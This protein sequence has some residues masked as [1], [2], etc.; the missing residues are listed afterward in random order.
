VTDEQIRELLTHGIHPRWQKAHTKLLDALVQELPHW[1][2]E[3][4]KADLLEGTSAEHLRQH[5]VEFITHVITRELQYIN[6]LRLRYAEFNKR[7]AR[8]ATEEEKRQHV[9]DY[10]QDLGAGKR[11]LASDRRAF[12]RWFGH[13]AVTDRYSRRHAGAERKIAMCLQR[14]GALAAFVLSHDGPTVGYRQ[15]WTRLDLETLSKS[16]LTYDGDV[17]V[18]IEA[19]RCL[20]TA[21]QAL[22]SELQEGSVNEKTLQYIYRAAIDTRQQVWIQCEALRL[23]QS[24]SAEALWTALERRLSQPH[25]GDDLFVRRR[26][27]LVLGEN[28][29]RLPHL[30]TLIPTA[31]RDPSP[32]VRQ[33][34]ARALRSATLEDIQTWLHHLACQDTTPQVRAAALL[35]V[36]VLLDRTALFDILAGIVADSLERE[37][38]S[39]VLRVAL[40][41]VTDGVLHYMQEGKD[42]LIQYWQEQLLPRIETL[43]READSLSVRRWAAQAWERIWCESDPRARALRQQLEHTVAGLRSGKSMRLPHRVLDGYDDEMVGRVLS[44]M[45]QD[46]FGYDIKRG[47]WG[48]RITRGHVFGLRWWRV[49]YE[50]RHPSPDKR[51]AFRHTIGRHFRGFLRAPSAILAELAETKVPGEPLHL[52]TESGW[53]PYLPL[54]DEVLSCLDETLRPQP[55]QIFTSEGVTTLTPPTSLWQRL[56]AQVELARNFAHYARLRNWQEQ[57]QASPNAY[58]QAVRKLGLRVHFRTHQPAS[59]RALSADPAVE[60]FF[61]AALPFS[62]GEWWPR[63]QEYFFSAYENSL[64]ELSI[65]MTLA[66]GFFIG[67][68]LYLNYTL[69]RVRDRFP[70]VVGGWGTRG[71]SGTE[72]IKAAMLNALGYSIVSKTTGCEAMFLH[73]HPFHQV[74]EMFLFRPYDKATIWE[75]ANLMRLADKLDTDVFLWECMALSPSYVYLLQKHWVRDEIATITNTFP[76][77]EDIQGPAGI[78]IPQVMVNFIPRGTTLFT[79]EEQMK[80]ILDEG[81][82]DLD[83]TIGGVGWL[84]AGLLTPDVLARFPYNE[85]PYNIAL[86]LAVGEELGIEQDFAL[87]EMAD[88]VVA[89]IGVL[90]VY[91]VATLRSRRLEFSNGM[92]ANERF[93]AISNWIR[94]GFDKQDPEQEP[95]VWITTVVNNRADRIARSRVFGGVLVEDVSAD[96]HFLIGSN[97]QGLVG[98]VQ[99]SWQRYAQPLT[100]WPDSGEDPQTAFRG[101]ARRLRVPTSEQQ[102]M[103]KLR[104][105]LQGQNTKLDIDAIVALWQDPQKVREFLSTA[106]LE[107]Y[108]DAIVNHLQKDTEMYQEYAAFSGRLATVEVSQKER[109]NQ[110]CRELLWKWF[111]DKFVVIDDYFATGDQ[112]INRICEETP[113]GFLNRIMGLQNIKGPGLGF[114]Y[115]WQAWDNCYKAATQL[116]SSDPLTANQGLRALASF[117]EYGLLCEEYVRETI[118][119]VRH[120]PLAQSER[121]QAELSVISSNLIAEM[122][123]VT[124]QMNVVRATGRIVKL[125]EAIEAFI[126]AG[127]AVRRRKRADRIYKDLVSEQ[128]S[129]QRAVVELQALTKRQKGGWL[130]DE[131]QGFQEALQGISE[132]WRP[133]ALLQRLRTSIKALGVG[134]DVRA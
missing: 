30:A 109:F 99:E 76:D 3:S 102:V 40:K 53:R 91:P 28:L 41:V 125:I 8:A 61:A 5:L 92:S 14:L 42:H 64:F 106:G 65:F 121:F 38:D 17:R 129:H 113:P 26:A 27:V 83:T 124:A 54:V 80:P 94:L 132:N 6:T 31:A 23:L 88:Y 56:R 2:A 43:H 24:L 133:Q 123:K 108:A 51:Q 79:S 82:C 93:G 35:E 70:L 37:K 72:R 18:R 55:V 50:V 97:L 111:Q 39:F 67:R 110:E 63:V 95:G 96:R 81:A 12:S 127:D 58:V 49:L 68:H 98:Y 15:L 75:Q 48:T 22:P 114:V 21:L 69:R 104:A 59:G 90:K 105:M 122:E 36:T 116:R 45:S 112:I 85:H 117:Q 101:M 29:R 62:S 20:S 44:V 118:E 100:L 87:K 57:G 86:V 78:N 73:G 107:V 16:L 34:L 126:D 119:T 130:L 71:K 77:H 13:D 66:V 32:Y 89:D 1:L 7:Y 120:K 103:A 46:N 47:L 131:L 11:Q 4:G 115:C 60:R 128:I 74:R 10:A 25:A 134:R 19:F 9:L 52:A 33:A 84:E